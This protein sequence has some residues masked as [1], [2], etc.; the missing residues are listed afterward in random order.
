MIKGTKGTLC[1]MRVVNYDPKQVNEISRM[2]TK[3]RSENSNTVRKDALP[4]YVTKYSDKRKN[5]SSNTRTN[6]RCCHYENTRPSNLIEVKTHKRNMCWKG[7][8]ENSETFNANH[9]RLKNIR[10]IT[11]NT[12]HSTHKPYRLQKKQEKAGKVQSDAQSRLNIMTRQETSSPVNQKSH[13][14]HNKKVEENEKIID[15]KNKG[16]ENLGTPGKT[17]IMRI[18]DPNNH[19]TKLIKP[20]SVVYSNLH[21]THSS[22]KNKIYKDTDRNTK[23]TPVKTSSECRFQ[24]KE[25]S[26]VSNYT[27]NQPIFNL[28]SHNFEGLGG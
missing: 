6:G 27:I 10:Y 16:P 9:K 5:T 22:K 21:M 13:K 14:R 11:N 7:Q 18:V 23:G 19:F 12:S 20:K 2:K 15:S 26:N 8:S 25:P 3:V 28:H 17:D 24:S 1:N 4:Q